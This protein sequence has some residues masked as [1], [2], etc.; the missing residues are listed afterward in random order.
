[1][2]DSASV[3]RPVIAS[4]GNDPMSPVSTVGPVF[5]TPDPATTPKLA[6]ATRGRA[7][8]CSGGGIGG[9]GTVG[10]VGTVTTGLVTGGTDTT[11]TRGTD[12]PTG[13]VGKG[14]A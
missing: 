4:V 7:G 9:V 10:T 14:V 6:L 11:G 3:E 2:P 13:S 12:T 5:V 8:G 1:M